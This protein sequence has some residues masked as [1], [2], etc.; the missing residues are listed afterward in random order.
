MVRT[1]EMD[2]SGG[3]RKTLRKAVNRV[4][5]N[6]YEAEL[7]TVADL[8]PATLAELEDVSACWRD[9]A[10]E[11]GFSMAH[12]TLV[13]ELL[14]DALVLVTRDEDG[15]VRGFLHFVPV[16]GARVVSLGFMRRERDTPNGLTEFMVVAAARELAARGIEE[17][18]LNFIAGGRW[19]RE[20]ANVVER[21]VA[22]FLRI[23][24]RWLQI[25]RLLRFNQKFEPRWQPR[26]L[27][28]ERATDLPRV[29]LGAMVAEGQVPTPAQLRKLGPS[30]SP[31]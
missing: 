15:R 1:G 8:P 7:V 24:D 27:L 9:G 29:A 23:A 17:F 25:E 14:P 2:L 21:A 16:C 12:D 4:A 22:G 13:D 18:S 30:P 11:R 6:G 3:S 5:R 10:P 26:H 19:L 31:S 20:P 28:F